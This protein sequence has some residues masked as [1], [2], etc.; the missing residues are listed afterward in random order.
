[1]RQIYDSRP[2]QLWSRNLPGCST[3]PSVSHGVNRNGTFACR[4][5]LP[6]ILLTA[7]GT[8]VI[9]L[10][11]L[12]DNSCKE[13]DS[14]FPSSQAK[15]LHSKT[16]SQASTCISGNLY[17][18]TVGYLACQIIRTP[19]MLLLCS[20]WATAFLRD[21]GN[22]WKKHLLRLGLC[23]QTEQVMLRK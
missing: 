6:G 22:S 11:G 23:V 21:T 5:D 13:R 7:V 4:K 16:W 15:S 17:A 10:V 19:G 14:Q 3:T 9:V 2:A 1:M 8:A 18:A 12:G 20:M